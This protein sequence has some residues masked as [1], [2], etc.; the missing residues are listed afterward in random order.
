MTCITLN[1]HILMK[2]AQRKHI[3][4]WNWDI[5][6]SLTMI[7]LNLMP[8]TNFQKVETGSSLCCIISCFDKKSGSI[9]QSYSCSTGCCLLRRT[10]H[11]IMHYTFFSVGDEWEPQEKQFSTWIIGRWSQLVIIHAECCLALSYQ[12]KQILPIVG[13]VAPNLY[14]WRLHRQCALTH[15]WTLHL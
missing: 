3:K 14:M 8:A 5:S 4:C 13:Y 12:K 9:S 11:F 1:H 15:L 10:L 7:L 2:K 6:L